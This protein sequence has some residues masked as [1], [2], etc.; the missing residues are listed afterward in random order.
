MYHKAVKILFGVIIG[1]SLSL[2]YY[3]FFIKETR[4]V[5]TPIIESIARPL[6]KYTIDNLTLRGGVASDIIL[7]E[8][9]ATT[10]AYT[11]YLFHYKSD[12]KKVTG[13]AHVP[14]GTGPHPVIVQFR[15]Y[16]DRAIYTPGIG[17]RR[18]AEV[19]AQ[20]GFISFAPDFLGY[21]GSDMPSEN[22][23]EERFQTYT[24]AMDLLASI[25][26]EHVGIWAHSNGGQIALTALIAL[27]KPI[28]IALWAPQSAYF[29]YSIL[30]YTDDADDK[31]TLL[32]KKLAEFESVYD[33][34]AY[35]MR[36]YLDR[37]QS[38]IQIH[39]GGS[40]EAIPKRWTDDFVEAL[41][42]SDKTVTY[43]TYPN[44]DHDMRPDWNT[45][46][47][48]DVEFYTKQFTTEER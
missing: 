20:N 37:L 47:S 23:F 44:A 45:V 10:S 11:A 28:P 21:G 18:S 34:D 30:Y 17:T 48:R 35:T 27:Q 25:K 41:K 26:A 31:G 3:A 32:R 40:D 7:D 43:F 15:G 2:V 42:K 33:A 29:P 36:N 4:S 46:V 19:F 39:Q 13:L 6:E 14:N 9:V 22:I 12:N 38:P 5:V 16:V 1:I 8:A 24:V